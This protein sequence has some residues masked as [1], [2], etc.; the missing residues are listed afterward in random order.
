MA[1]AETAYALSM[2][3]NATNASSPGGGINFSEQHLWFCSGVTAPDPA[4]DCAIGWTMDA[5]LQALQARGVYREGCYPWDVTRG[6]RICEPGSAFWD[7]SHPYPVSS[8]SNSS[9]SVP[10][11]CGKVPGR[12]EVLKRDWDGVD[13]VNA[14]AVKQLVRQAGSAMACFRLYED[15]YEHGGGVYRW[16]GASRQEGWHCAQLLGWD[17]P[18]GYWLFKSSW[19]TSVGDKGFFKVRRVHGTVQVRDYG[20]VAALWDTVGTALSGIRCDAAASEPGLEK[21]KGLRGTASVANISLPPRVLCSLRMAR[22]TFLRGAC[23]PSCTTP[24]RGA[25][26]SGQ[27]EVQDPRG[28]HGW[29]SCGH[30]QAVATA[31][32]QEQ[33]LWASSGRR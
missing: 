13:Q 30:A 12:W 18:Q 7:P 6:S 32:R 22:R 14:T 5:A 19:G 15:M 25:A 23:G 3:L 33:A 16:D 9:R 11:S 29:H 17:D 4:P 2:G 31:G 10:S 8:S 21:H 26:R 28:G 20:A 27:E 24:S 1:A